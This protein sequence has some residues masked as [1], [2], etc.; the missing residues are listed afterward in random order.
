MDRDEQPGIDAPYQMIVR[1]LTGQDGWLLTVFQSPEGEQFY[2]G[3]YFPPEDL[4][5]RIGLKLLM[6][7]C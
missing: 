7:A 3:T 5:G 2:G 4:H 1:M 6:S